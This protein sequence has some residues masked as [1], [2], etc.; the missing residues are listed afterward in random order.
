MLTG[1]LHPDVGTAALYALFLSFCC[2]I[3]PHLAL[4]E[5]FFARRVMCV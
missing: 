4:T 5:L 2:C 1:I 3:K